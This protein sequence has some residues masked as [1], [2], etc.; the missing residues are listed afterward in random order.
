[1]ANKHVKRYLILF[2][3]RKM[4]IKFTIPHKKIAIPLYAHGVAEM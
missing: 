1:M 4:Q 3:I 2:I